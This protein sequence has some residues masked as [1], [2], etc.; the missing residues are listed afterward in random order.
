MNTL[1]LEVKGLVVTYDSKIEKILRDDKTLMR[2]I[3]VQLAK[4][5]RK[6]ER[7]LES[8]NNFLDYL[9]YGLGKPHSLEDSKGNKNEGYYGISLTGNYRLIVKPNCKK[10]NPGS[11]KECEEV[12][13]IGVRD[14]HGKN[15]EW[16]MP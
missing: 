14:Y 3:D 6:R 16:L 12:I 5:I 13:I 15:E 8:F 10:N 2:T 1:K 9:Q 4:S 7:D 11:L